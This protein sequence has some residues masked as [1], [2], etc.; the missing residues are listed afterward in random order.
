M[1]QIVRSS[2]ILMLITTWLLAKFFHPFGGAG[3]MEWLFKWGAKGN[4]WMS[5][6]LCENF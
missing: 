1:A 6:N 4:E 3:A 5:F 2:P